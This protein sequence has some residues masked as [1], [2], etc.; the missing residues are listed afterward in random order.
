MSAGAGRLYSYTL[1][2]RVEERQHSLPVIIAPGL[3]E[4]PEAGGVRIM[5]AIVDT[6]PDALRI[7][8]SLILGWAENVDT[9]IPVFSVA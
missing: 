9:N 2:E 7:G 3:V 5:A 1:L 4:F 8:V 6:P